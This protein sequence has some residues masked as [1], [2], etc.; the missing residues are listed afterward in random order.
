MAHDDSTDASPALAQKSDAARFDAGASPTASTRRRFLSRANGALSQYEDLKNRIRSWRAAAES[1]EQLNRADAFHAECAELHAELI[2]LRD[3]A[4][5]S[6]A[7]APVAAALRSAVLELRVILTFPASAL[8]EAQQ[9]IAEGRS[10]SLE[11]VEHEMG[12]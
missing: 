3:E 4:G 12:H 5:R 8:R 6:P 2:A 10:R 7:D 1:A 11:S 9:R